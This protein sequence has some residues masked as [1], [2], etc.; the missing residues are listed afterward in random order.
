M[1][2]SAKGCKTAPIDAN[3]I[4]AV[5]VKNDVFHCT[6]PPLSQKKMVSQHR[7]RTKHQRTSGQNPHCAPEHQTSG[8]KCKG[9]AGVTGKV[10]TASPTCSSPRCL[11]L[12]KFR[13]RA[14]AHPLI[15]D[16]VGLSVLARSTGLHRKQ[17]AP[18]HLWRIPS[19]PFQCSCCFHHQSLFGDQ[20]QGDTTMVGEAPLIR[21]PPFSINQ[22][23]R[24]SYHFTKHKTPK[25][26]QVQPVQPGQGRPGRR[27][28]PQHHACERRSWRHMV[29]V[30]GRLW[31]LFYTL[32]FFISCYSI[33]LSVFPL[34]K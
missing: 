11:L 3:E 20:Q 7:S 17:E 1:L 5:K 26:C 33:H 13:L 24:R 12:Q 32:H 18:T 25:Q 28:A 2:L 8:H 21:I 23:H 22:N 34:L 29:Q 30:T 16:G 10:T 4:K 15:A 19:H 31:N 27:G 14:Q 6:V 9:S